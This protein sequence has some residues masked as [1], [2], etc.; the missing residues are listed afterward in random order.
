MSGAEA[1]AGA[2]AGAGAAD[3]LGV[4]ARAGE[5]SRA[6]LVDRRMGVEETLALEHAATSESNHWRAAT[7]GS[8]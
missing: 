1:G 6:P 2:G 5:G 7:N 8:H 3:A 4:A